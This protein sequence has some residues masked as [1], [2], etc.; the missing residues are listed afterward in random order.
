MVFTDVS[1]ELEA[2]LKQEL[3]H[4]ERLDT[5]FVEYL[6]SRDM[7]PASRSDSAAGSLHHTY[8]LLS[9]ELQVYPRKPHL[10]YYGQGFFVCFFLFFFPLLHLFLLLYTLMLSGCP[11][12]AE[13]CVPRELQSSV[14]V[15]S[16]RSCWTASPRLRGG[17]TPIL[18]KRETGLAGDSAVT[19]RAP[20]QDG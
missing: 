9:P 12:H 14:S 19:P 17:S 15:P 16:S 20:L 11:G 13:P 1:S 6:R 3:E 10:Q 5:H 4:T 2:K 7:A 8:E 18:A